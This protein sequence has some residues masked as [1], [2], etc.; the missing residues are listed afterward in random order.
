MQVKSKLHSFDI[1]LD[2]LYGKPGTPSRDAFRREARA[3]CEEKTASKKAAE[4]KTAVL[5]H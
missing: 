5:S 2:E 3:F 1:V 4:H